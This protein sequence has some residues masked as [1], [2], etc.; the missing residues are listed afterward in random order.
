MLLCS[1]TCG[2]VSVID[3]AVILTQVMTI[4]GHAVR[5]TFAQEDNVETMQEVRDILASAL[6]S[7]HCLQLF[8][9]GGVTDEQAV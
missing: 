2:E 9:E 5:M 1:T 4:D 3:K 7:P 6:E 8:S